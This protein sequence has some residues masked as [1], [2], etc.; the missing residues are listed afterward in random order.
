MIR[1]MIVMLAASILVAC[2]LF[3]DY[4]GPGATGGPLV[5]GDAPTPP[6]AGDSLI[7]RKIINHDV[8]VR[9]TMTSYSSEVVVNPVARDGDY[10]EAA[11]D[12]DY[13]VGVEIQ[14]RRK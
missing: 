7:E 11:R 10:V 9:A 13:E 8:V 2:G 5:A 6:N 4:E 12:G 14:P 3:D 1:V